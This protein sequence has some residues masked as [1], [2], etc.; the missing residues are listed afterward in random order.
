MRKIPFLT[1]LAAGAI[2]SFTPLTNVHAAGISVGVPA[3]VQTMEPNGAS[4]DSNLS[5]MANIFD[6]L[7]QRDA[8]GK[9]IP[10]LAESWERVD[11]LTWRFK[12]R[13]GVKFQNGNDFT[14]DDVIFSFKRIAT[15][16]LSAFVN[17]GKQIESVTTVDGDPWT[18]EVKTVVPVPFF[19]QNL[20]QIFMM[21][22]ESTEN[23]KPGDV[24]QH[25]IGTGAYSLA[26]WVKGS[27]VKLKANPNYWEGAPEIKEATIR[28][29]VEGSTA[30]ASIMSGTVDVLQGVPVEGVKVL[31]KNPKLTLVK[32]PARRAIFLG[33][34]NAKGKPGADL[35]VREA[36]A[37]AI[38]EEKIIQK[39]MFG[40]AAP[41]AQV[42]D[43]ATVGYNP[44]I[45][46]AKYDPE[47]SRK[48]LAEAG[49]PN[50]FDITLSGPNNRY[51]NDEKI[52]AAVAADLAK[53]GIKVKVDAKP[54]SIIFDEYKQHKPEF[55]LLGW[56][57]GSY[58]F[59]R[60][61]AKLLHTYDETKGTGT[62]NAANYSNPELD[63]IAEK[64]SNTID[65]KER[66][67][68]LQE[69]GVKLQDA[70]GFIPLHYQ[71]D[72]Y[73]IT[74][75]KGFDFKPRPDTWIVF[76]QIGKKG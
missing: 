68:V 4:T 8:S 66:A 33:L 67:K 73:A 22:K 15:P 25:P 34:T 52:L 32:R 19:D 20:H 44:A 23:R 29:A 26:E 74:N 13:Q 35:R 16:E 3:D 63:A 60:S 39:V 5:V 27:H 46:R 71:M 1:L 31:E 43:P 9:L 56:F 45:K 65:P 28:P 54:K 12:L 48:L 24:G 7:L 49:Y 61:F 38:N 58:D 59:G 72:L 41:A 55:Y 62:W 70:F 11:A 50:G 51:V 69:L 64:A 76:K 2:A 14:A 36:I 42:S 18:V 53:V 37:H 57:D 75:A 6:G 47:L 10:A 21:D 30:M 40:F 17:F